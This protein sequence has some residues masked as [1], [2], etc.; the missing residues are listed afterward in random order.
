MPIIEEILRADFKKYTD[1]DGMISD[2]PNPGRGSSGNLILYTSSYAW[3]LHK[4]GYFNHNDF[5]ELFSS[6]LKCEIENGVFARCPQQCA[7]RYNQNGPDDAIGLISMSTIDAF[8]FAESWLEHGSNNYYPIG[9][10]LR[11]DGHNV[12]AFIFGWIKLRWVFNTIDTNG[13]VYVEITD[14][15]NNATEPH[16]NWKAWHGRFPS[17]IA[18]AQFAAREKFPVE[19]LVLALGLIPVAFKVASGLGLWN[20]LLVPAL[21]ISLTI[22][23]LG[24]RRIVWAISVFT[25]GRGKQIDDTDPWILTWHLVQTFYAS[26]Q[27]SIMCDFVSRNFMRRLF[28]HWP[29]GL[30]SVY[31][32]YGWKDHPM[33]EYFLS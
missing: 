19:R 30:N 29:A 5:T 28:A 31:L 2:Q 33:T 11:V 22:L 7:Q 24:F 20:L 3:I 1:P 32:K 16:S 12:L 13:L 17:I 27:N 14:P 25:A 4:R 6:F 18:H 10:A 21:F 8:L 26:G 9:P 15:E 23:A